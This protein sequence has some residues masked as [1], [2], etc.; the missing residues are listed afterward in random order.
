MAGCSPT[1]TPIHGTPRRSKRSVI[2]VIQR[3]PGVNI[4]DTVERIKAALPRLQAAIPPGID[5]AIV[6]DR[7]QTIRASIN[8]VQFTL[9]LTIALVVLVIFLFLRD[10]R[11][12]LIPSVTVPLS[13]IGT[14]DAM[15]LLGYSM[16]NLSLMP[17][18]SRPGSRW[19][20]PLSWSRT[21]RAIWRKAVRRS[22]LR[23]KEIGFTIGS[24]SISLIA[25]FIPILLLGGLIGRLFPEFAVTVSVAILL[26]ICRNA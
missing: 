4:I 8:D 26:T 13:L 23:A 21:L 19:T 1:G 22:K 17:L 10:L 16:D 15:Y 18:R 25:V 12:T 5:V 7:T 9:I 14:F 2:L 6:T 20:M 24:I 11:A 3:Q